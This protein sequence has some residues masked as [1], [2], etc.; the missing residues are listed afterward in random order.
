MFIMHNGSYFRNNK[1]LILKPYTSKMI[2]KFRTKM[3]VVTKKCYESN[4]SKIIL[5]DF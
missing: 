4:T 2:D 5:F 1:F 3:A